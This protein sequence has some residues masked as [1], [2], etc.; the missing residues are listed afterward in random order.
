MIQLDG[1]AD[2]GMMVVLGAISSVHCTVMCGP[3]IAVACAPLGNESGSFVQRGRQLALWQAAYHLGRG[4]SYAALG[5]L[6]GWTGALLATLFPTRLVG[7]SLQLAVGLVVV[8][9]ALW[10]V[11]PWR[12][13]A[14]ASETT[15]VG[16]QLGRWLTAARPGALLGLGLL[17]GL[18]PC[19][20]LY[21]AFARALTAGSTLSA[22]V[23]MGCFWIGTV[24]LLL[25]VAT[26]AGG[27]LRAISRR[28]ATALVLTAAL[29]T[30]G[31]I[32][33]KGVCN[34]LASDAAPPCHGAPAASAGI[35]S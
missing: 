11:L 8:G 20:V 27:L 6:L 10:T 19:G 16:R 33:Y 15:W 17:T 30:G 26:G 4:L 29:A 34:V 13:T 32:A 21:A 2:L 12:R 24:P 25:A 3:L 28:Y 23:L 31:W 14:G 22:A 35:Q 18:L 9:A 1:M 5:A 7:G